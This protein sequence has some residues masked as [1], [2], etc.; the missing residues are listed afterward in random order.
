[1]YNVIEVS[2]QNHLVLPLILF[3]NATKIIAKP[4]N[5]DFS[6]EEKGV[7]EFIS[8]KQLT[9]GIKRTMLP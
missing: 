3:C 1:M 5:R 8:V 2:L 4:D 6:T 7:I 9:L